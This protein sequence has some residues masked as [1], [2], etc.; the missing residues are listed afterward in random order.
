MKRSVFV[1]LSSSA[2]IFGALWLSG[3]SNA[4]SNTDTHDEHGEHDHGEHEHG[5]G[6]H[7]DATMKAENLAKLSP[8]DQA[9]AESQKVCPVTG[10]PLGSMGV[11]LKVS[12][13]GRDV[14]IC[15]KGCQ[16]K[17]QENPEKYL[18]NLPKP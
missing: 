8:A 1:I 14:F 16:K 12:V 4:A 6:D 7:A 3:C 11:P 18:A 10:E 17:I 13:E 15:C 5:D 9:L 2:A